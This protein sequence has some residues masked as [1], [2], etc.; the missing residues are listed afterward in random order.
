MQPPAPVTKIDPVISFTRV[1]LS[2]WPPA[3]CALAGDPHSRTTQ[4]TLSIAKA[5]QMRFAGCLITKAICDTHKIL[6]IARPVYP[7]PGPNPQTASV[8]TNQP[9]KAT[10]CCA[11]NSTDVRIPSVLSRFVACVRS[12]GHRNLPLPVPHS[13][14]PCNSTISR[15]SCVSS[16]HTASKDA[17]KS[18]APDPHKIVVYKNGG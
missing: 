17:G 6:L 15:G 2:Y 18:K 13:A 11:N 12:T 10:T 8:M 3:V 5:L 9:A 1:C 14:H 7:I 16:S 4:L